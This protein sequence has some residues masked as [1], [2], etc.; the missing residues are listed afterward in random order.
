[1]LDVAGA[2]RREDRFYVGSHQ[3]PQRIQQFQQ[4]VLAVAGDIE[5]LP[6]R[7]GRMACQEIRFYNIT[8]VTEVT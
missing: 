4:R 6:D 2:G 8:D 1:M 5:D 3:P 7:P